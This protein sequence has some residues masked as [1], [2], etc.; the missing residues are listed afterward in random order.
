MLSV[1]VWLGV[2]SVLCF[3][4]ARPTAMQKRRSTGVPQSGSSAQASEAF[5]DSGV[6]QPAENE[7]SRILLV[8]AGWI[9]P[10]IVKKPR[11][12]PKKPS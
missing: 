7:G 6:S 3:P 2:F 11:K 9:R 12:R 4:L 8:D 10:Q 5:R 1:E